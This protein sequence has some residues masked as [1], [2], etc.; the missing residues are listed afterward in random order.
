MPICSAGVD[1]AI[2][3][4]RQ[5]PPT[6][7]NPA[8]RPRTFRSTLSIIRSRG[9]DTGT[10]PALRITPD[11]Q[12]TSAESS[13]AHRAPSILCC[14]SR[15][16]SSTQSRP[17]TAFYSPLSCPRGMRKTSSAPALDSLVA[18][19][20][21]GFELGREWEILVV[22]DA[23]TD[24]TRSAS[25]AGVP[26]PSPHSPPPPLDLPAPPRRLHRQEQRLLDTEPRPPSGTLLLFTDA[27]TLYEPGSLSRARHEARKVF[28]VGAAL[29]LAPP[30]RQPAFAQRTLM[31]LIFA[32]LSI[33]YP[34]KRVNDRTATASPRPT[35]SSSSSSLKPTS[36]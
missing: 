6:I 26:V 34:M 18:Q 5:A 21:P 16:L 20:E 30:A 9:Q 10:D 13:R 23:S 8:I 36:P 1:P 19:S 11:E 29:L 7:S 31:P 28:D 15:P 12:S 3:A 25:P 35:V 22:D 27:D 33:A 17:P 32:E 24:A 14:A 2:A 4:R